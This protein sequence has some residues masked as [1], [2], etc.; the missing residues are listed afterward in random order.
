MDEMGLGSESL[1]SL[2]VG[3]KAGGTC[4]QRGPILLAVYTYTHTYTIFG[5]LRQGQGFSMQL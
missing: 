5:F 4:M 3:D 1:F 2:S